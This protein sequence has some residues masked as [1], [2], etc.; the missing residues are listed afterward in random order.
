[1]RKH[2]FDLKDCPQTTPAEHQVVVYN[3]FFMKWKYKQL[4]ILAL[5]ITKNIYTKVQGRVSYL[6]WH[7]VTT[8]R[9]VQ[10]L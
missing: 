3:L 7:C 5:Y 4:L 10:I 9:R 6:Q 8:L 2:T 1:M